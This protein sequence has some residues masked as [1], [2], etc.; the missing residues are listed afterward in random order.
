MGGG[1]P[2]AYT[3][4]NTG[5]LQVAITIS[6]ISINT[7]TAIGWTIVIN[8]YADHEGNDGF[9]PY[10]MIRQTKIPLHSD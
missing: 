6:L 4:P 9:C 3:P 10:N 7:I 8:S 1:G 5:I 2:L